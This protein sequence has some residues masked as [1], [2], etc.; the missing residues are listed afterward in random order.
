MR[1][2]CRFGWPY[3]LEGPTSAQLNLSFCVAALLL[4][5][6]VFVEQ[7]DGSCV[8]DE[9]RIALSRYDARSKIEGSDC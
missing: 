7:F 4:E 9:R 8:T 5:G 3:R 1:Q 2:A 6:D